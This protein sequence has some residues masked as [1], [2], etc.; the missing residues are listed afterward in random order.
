[1]GVTV[2]PT[3]PA[4]RLMPMPSSSAPPPISICPW[5]RRASCASPRITSAS[6]LFRCS[7]RTAALPFVKDAGEFEIAQHPGTMS[8]TLFSRVRTP[9]FAAG[10]V[11]ETTMTDSASGALT[12]FSA[13]APG[14]ETMLPGQWVKYKVTSLPLAAPLRPPARPRLE[15]IRRR[16]LGSIVSGLNSL[17]LKA[18]ECP[19]GALT[20]ASFFVLNPSLP[21]PLKSTS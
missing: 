16:M 4:T 15:T 18:V 17:Y 8:A 19:R 20:G 9:G 3:S 5:S 1:M 10:S 2:H 7:P 14:Y 21:M 11:R 12:I 6:R 13:E